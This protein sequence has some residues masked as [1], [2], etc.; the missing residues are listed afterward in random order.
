[1]KSPFRHLAGKHSS[2]ANMSGSPSEMQVGRSN[3]SQSQ[4]YFHLPLQYRRPLRTSRYIT[5][6]QVTAPRA[7]F[8]FSTCIS[9][10]LSLWDTELGHTETGKLPI[11]VGIPT[12]QEHTHS[13]SRPGETCTSITQDFSGTIV[14]SLNQSY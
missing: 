2:C 3:P 14:L 9:L 12:A 4:F 6:N 7:K 11:S 5:P 10:C 1:M 8:W 13:S